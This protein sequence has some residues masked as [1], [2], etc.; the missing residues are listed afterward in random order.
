MSKVSAKKKGGAK[1]KAKAATKAEQVLLPEDET[2]KLNL[3][4]L[5]I[6]AASKALSLEE[7]RGTLVSVK[8]VNA[9][10]GGVL[11]A[12]QTSLDQLPKKIVSQ[13]S[14]KSSAAL[15]AWAIENCDDSLEE[16]R[17]RLEDFMK[18]K[19]AQAD[20][21]TGRGRP[22]GATTKKG[23]ARRATGSKEKGA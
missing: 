22:K 10:F 3:E 9:L 14:K 20:P 13:A 16:M 18:G 19:T 12:V 8:E 6:N 15:L 1:P 4:L 7:Q 11:S 17:G 2:K 21:R 5:R 23:A